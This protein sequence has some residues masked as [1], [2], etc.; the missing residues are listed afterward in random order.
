MRGIKA[1]I[2]S[3][4]IIFLIALP[5]SIGVAVAA[6]IPPSAGILSAIVGGILGTFFTGSQLVIN[7]PA[8]GLIVVILAAVSSLGDGDP[9]LGFRRTLAATVAAGLLQVCFGILKMGRLA[10]LAPSSV[11]H[12]ML[13]AI[14]VIILIKQIPVLFG[15]FSHSQSIVGMALEVP[16]YVF[17]AD[18]PIAITGIC[19][20][21]LLILWNYYGGHWR[22]IVPAPLMVVALGMI[23]SFVFKI[24]E[25]HDVRFFDHTYHIGPEFLV[26][27][28]T[29]IARMIILPQFDI[30]FSV[31]SFIVIF[32]IFI[33]ASLESLLSAYAI[34]KL[35]PRGRRS[36]L[37][38]DL[39]GKG[40]VN[41]ACGFMGAYPVIAEIVRSSANIDN[42]AQTKW[43]NFFHGVFILVFIVLF[44]NFINQIPLA[45]LSA[46]LII[47]GF[48][49]AHPRH[50]KEAYYHGIDQFLIFCTT[51]VITLAEDLLVGIFLGVV[52]K[53][54][55]HF[56]RG[57]KFNQFF[58]PHITVKE[59]GQ[60]VLIEFRSPIVFLGVLRLRK[61]LKQHEGKSIYI[62]TGEHFVDFTVREMIKDSS[63]HV[64]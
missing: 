57:V 23:F 6:G 3:G 46:V 64:L 22:K 38:K 32:T 37:D 24:S 15:S 29:N 48:N 12:G 42:G 55:L 16:N 5:L 20:L 40:V 33:V 34:D 14:G 54:I 31:R 52:L 11:V 10:F 56:F 1:D 43:S 49:L 2:V 61:I 39:L 35:D 50:F 7:G 45:A 27:V 59:R 41:I 8:A 62:D 18:L 13:S 9:V 21:M 30:I 53:I 58:N 63:H 4:F 36:D 44:P 25:S 17:S 47:V 51:F 28:P 60:K 19:C 26:H